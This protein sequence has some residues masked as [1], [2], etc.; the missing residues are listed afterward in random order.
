MSAIGFDE[1]L[2]IQSAA[3]VINQMHESYSAI[4][5]ANSV[6]LCRRAEGAAPPAVVVSVRSQQ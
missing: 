5:R 4:H 2:G 1:V 3:A 6:S